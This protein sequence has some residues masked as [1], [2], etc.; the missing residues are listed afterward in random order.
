MTLVTT[1]KRVPV[2]KNCQYKIRKQG[3]SV[4][5]GDSPHERK[6]KKLINDSIKAKKQYSNLELPAILLILWQSVGNIQLDSC[7]RSVIL[8]IYSVFNLSFLVH[9]ILIKFRQHR[10]IQLAGLLV[11]NRQT[12]Q[13]PR[14]NMFASKEAFM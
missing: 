6:L 7:I 12:F 3:T 1:Y 2:L 10:V 13:N 9:N 4:A 11:E 8:F 14:V 5:A